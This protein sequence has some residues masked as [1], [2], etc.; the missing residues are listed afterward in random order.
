MITCTLVSP[1]TSTTISITI[2]TV[3]LSSKISTS[4]QVGPLLIVTNTSKLSLMV[5]IKL[6]YISVDNSSLYKVDSNVLLY[7]FILLYISM[8]VYHRCSPHQ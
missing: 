5:F 2:S 8:Y 1:I 6:L 3:I 4:T 7:F